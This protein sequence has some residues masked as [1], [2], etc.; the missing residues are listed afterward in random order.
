MGTYRKLRSKVSQSMKSGSGAD[1]I[2][3]P[4]WPFYNVMAQFL[5]DV[6]NPRKTKNSEVSS[7]FT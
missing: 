2:Y 1:E 7:K 4:D 6:Y 5:D 3:M